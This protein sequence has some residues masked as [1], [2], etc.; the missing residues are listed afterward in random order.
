MAAGVPVPRSH[1][2]ADAATADAFVRESE[3]AWVVKADGLALGKGVFVCNSVDE[4]LAAIDRVARRRDFGTAG[5]RFI[6][7]ERLH[8]RELSVFALCDGAAFRVIGAARDYKRA[9]DGDRGPNTGGMGAYTPVADLTPALQQR[10]EADILAPT[11]AE[12]RGRGAAFVGFLYAGLMLTDAGPVV[13]EFNSRMGDPEAQ[14][15]LPLLQFDLVEAM[16]AAISGELATLAPTSAAG[17]AVCVVMASAGYPGSYATGHSIEGLGSVVPDCLVF[18]AGSTRD[19]ERWLTAGGRV[20][21][22][23]GLGDTVGE[24][25]ERA[26]A[27]VATVRFDGA[28]WRSDI[29]A[30]TT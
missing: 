6:L 23:C 17:A 21:A 3:R 10:I 30:E 15:L 26:Y 16:S 28:M 2:F 5:D 13:I 9:S 19:G 4:T 11:L 8:G 24:A 22:V 18:H 27:G 29:A 14:V 20:L 1:V 7:Q 12:M 25:R